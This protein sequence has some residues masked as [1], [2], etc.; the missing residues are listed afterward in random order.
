MLHT[1]PPKIGNTYIIHII[2]EEMI[3]T[4]LSHKSHSLF[5]RILTHL[6]NIFNTF[7][8]SESK[9][10]LIKWQF[11]EYKIWLRVS[12]QYIMRLWRLTRSK[13]IESFP[14]IELWYPEFGREL[15]NGSSSSNLNFIYK[16]IFWSGRAYNLCNSVI[17]YSLHIAFHGNISNIS[18][19]W[20]NN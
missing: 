15:K 16:V 13:T 4:C 10:P 18:L 3:S 5:I 19:T 17:N 1:E 8:I 14:T 12:L 9:I 2:K 7:F 6:H 11:S 20:W